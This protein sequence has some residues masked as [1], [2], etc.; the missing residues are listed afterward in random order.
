MDEIPSSPG[1]ASLADRGAGASPAVTHKLDGGLTEHGGQLQGQVRLGG[2]HLRAGL[3]ARVQGEVVR[4]DGM[5][6]YTLEGTATG[7]I[8]A[9]GSVG[10]IGG[11]VRVQQGGTAR[12]E[13]ALP[14]RAARDADLRSI[15]PFDPAS[16]PVGTRISMDAAHTGSVEV[17]TRLRQLATRDRVGEEQ[18]VQMSVEALEGG[19]V[20]VVAGPREA[21]E[22]Y[23]GIGMKLG[24]AS[25]MLGREDRI[26]GGTLHSAEFD[27]SSPQ[28][29]H[30]YDEVMR[31]GAMPERDAPGL[32]QVTTV[33][34]LDMRSEGKVDLGIGSHGTTL[35]TGANS[36]QAVRTVHG[37]GSAEVSRTLRYREHDV[38]LQA[39]Q[40]F[41]ADGTPG[42][43]S[44]TYRFTPDATQAGQLN[45]VYGSDGRTPFQ[46][47][48]E[49]TL[50]FSEQEMAQLQVQTQRAN[51]NISRTGSND[52]IRLL[53][54]PAGRSPEAFATDLIHNPST[55]AS[56]PSTLYTVSLRSGEEARSRA[57]SFSPLPGQVEGTAAQ[58][59]QAPTPGMPPQSAPRV[60]FN[61]AATAQ[62]ALGH[63][64]HPD[65]PLYT[66]IRDRAP[67]GVGEDHL[68]Q[69]TLLARHE[70]ITVARLQH[71]GV[72]DQTL[73]LVGDLP[74]Q[75]ASVDL[76]QPAPQARETGAQLLAMQAL[77]PDSAQQA[78][79]Q[80]ERQAPLARG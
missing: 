14:E 13:V 52:A 26:S 50:R 17:T 37:D 58:A 2:E 3:D 61:T 67:A 16:M 70:G 57:L 28:G 59:P 42:E 65:T 78:L 32:S 74:G 25:A 40:P 77:Q 4:S 64:S 53:A 1:N 10:G 29:R 46:A 49:A 63:G 60:D 34:R 43:R 36:G 73:W 20:R 5:V 79:A 69:A 30:A 38:A 45:A 8:E 22:A 7:F 54:E 6:R 68:A 33:S 23:H 41:A 35:S 11:G 24:P 15:N 9:N 62:P 47:G 27:L 44:Y 48:Q 12:F 75:R 39:D 80:Q 21:V 51:Q 72:H 19:R 55:L 31:S 18:G 56:L 76:R 71:I 66:A